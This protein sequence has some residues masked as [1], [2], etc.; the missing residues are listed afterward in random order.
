MAKK[1]GQTFD[2]EIQYWPRTE[3]A[4][5]VLNPVT[6]ACAFRIESMYEEVFGCFGVPDMIGPKSK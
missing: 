1:R 5:I 2:F 3:S 4:R 6:F